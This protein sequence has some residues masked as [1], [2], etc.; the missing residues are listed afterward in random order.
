MGQEHK[1]LKSKHLSLIQEVR[2]HV[3]SVKESVKKTQSELERVKAEFAAV[4]RAVETCP[5]EKNHMDRSMVR[6]QSKCR[7]P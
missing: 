3:P 1:S 4:K 5:P 7:P 2:K 6:H